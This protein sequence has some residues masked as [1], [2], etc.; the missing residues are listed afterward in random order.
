MTSTTRCQHCANLIP[1]RPQP[2]ASRGLDE[3]L[4]VQGGKRFVLEGGFQ[5][6][7]QRGLAAAQARWTTSYVVSKM[8]GVGFFLKPRHVGPVLLADDVLVEQPDLQQALGRHLVSV[9]HKTGKMD[10]LRKSCMK[11][12]GFTA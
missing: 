5:G 9:L 11:G 12:E 2:R 3:Q 4:G 7:S 8:N 6:L 1:A 10:V